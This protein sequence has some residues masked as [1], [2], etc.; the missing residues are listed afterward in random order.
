MIKFTHKIAAQLKMTK[1]EFQY[2]LNIRLKAEETL[3]PPRPCPM[4]R[5]NHGGNPEPQSLQ[6]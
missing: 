3:Q 6:H 5:S 2:V 1:E 4:P